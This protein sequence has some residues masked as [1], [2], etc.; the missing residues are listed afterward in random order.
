MRKHHTKMMIREGRDTADRGSPALATWAMA[1]ENK[2][3]GL[4][5][6]TQLSREEVVE[7]APALIWDDMT[8]AAPSDALF[9]L[10]DCAWQR[11]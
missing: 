10:V 3:R 1:A 11:N 6:R 5:H 2:E 9:V 7:I 8:L 4:G